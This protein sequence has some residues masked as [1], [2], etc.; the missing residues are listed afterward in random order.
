[1]TARNE[2]SDWEECP[3]GTLGTLAVRSRR[4]RMVARAAW[5]VPLIALLLLALATSGFL[6]LGTD[7]DSRPLLCDRVVKLLPAYASNSLP[8]AER[9]QVELHLKKCLFCRT[10][11]QAIMDERSV[12]QNSRF[13]PHVGFSIWRLG[14]SS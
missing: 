9:K 8:A 2:L 6:P 1:M 5:A 13:S 11:L 12:A 10:K 7:S 3:R 14:L 4:R